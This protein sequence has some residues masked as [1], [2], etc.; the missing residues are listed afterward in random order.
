MNWKRSAICCVSFIA[1]F[2]GEIAV[3]IACGPEQDPYDYYVSYFHNNVQGDEYVPF[4]FNSM[5]ALFSEEEVASEAEINSAEWAAYLKVKK[6]D[7]LKAM[8][9]VDSAASAKLASFES[10]TID[11]LPDSLANNT[12]LDALTLAKN[13][14]AMD[15]YAY[16]KSCEPFASVNFDLWNPVVRD[17]IMMDK[18]AQEGL[19]LLRKAGGDDFLKLRYA[20]QAERLFHFAGNYQQSKSTYE[21]FI[22]P[23][24]TNS[25]AKGWALAVYAG[26]VRYTG[27]PAQAAFL[28]SKVF[29][30][31]PERR[32]QAYKNF[33]YTSAPVEEVLKYAKT[34]QE[35]ANVLA[36][37]SFGN[38]EPQ[39]EALQQVYRYVPS[40][41]LSGA[42][43][44]REVNK[45][46]EDLIK[47][48]DIAHNPYAAYLWRYDERNGKSDSTESLNKQR[49][50]KIRDF[51]L[52]L[53]ADKKYREPALGTVTAAY[54][55]WMEGNDGL[56]LSYL[57]K[58][59]AD[60]LNARLHDQY[61]IIELLIKGNQ[62]KRGSAFN[63]NDLLPALKW[64]DAKRFAENPDEAKNAYNNWFEGKDRFT[65]TTRNF[66]QQ[67]LAPAY[68]KMGDTAKAAMA[69]FKGDLKYR[70]TEASLDLS[71]M[72]YQTLTFFQN[73]LG[74]KTVQALAKI[75]Q[76][77][78]ADNVNGLL[79]HGF[80]KLNNDQ[81]YELC[82]TVY[83]RTHQ[84]AKALDWFKKVKNYS[85]FFEANNWYADE[86]MYSDPFPTTINDYPKRYAPL[87]KQVDKISFAKEMA[88]LQKLVVSDKKNAAS[89]YYKMANGVYQTGYYGNSWFLISYDWSSYFN[90][91]KP[92]YAHDIDFKLAKTAKAW[93]A[94]ARGLSNDVNFKAKCTFMLA[95]CEQK[96]IIINSNYYDLS[97]YNS[98]YKTQQQNFMAKN[99]N[100]PYFKELKASYAKTPYYKIAVNECSYLRDFLKGST[101]H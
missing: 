27:N 15:Y 74:P 11:E 1:V 4:A 23:I 50:V 71:S 40:S 91:N 101:V 93:Y 82:G 96:K 24:K 31:N 26:S 63:E 7:V 29:E 61:R 73:Y 99:I 5:V 2:F 100:N 78:Q 57:A 76:T 13:K 19:G 41:L 75:K 65:A 42:L 10:H 20:Y 56:A 70:K 79:A 30:S 54:L 39:V 51:A 21:K 3:N 59:N 35:K 89:Y 98:D 14:K 68:L 94:K 36:V 83:L 22:E 25:A 48:K 88:R 80:I 64:L 72:S 52:Q 46:E 67:V 69:M 77:P 85:A 55:S 44:V 33:F 43:L 92:V 28:Y 97:W 60:K 84:Y 53:A 58:V 37:K 47:D 87:G 18:K 62:I 32:I 95:K 45:L 12:F 49:L 17:S 86:K 90:Y 8:Y 6:E 9:Q 66:Y 16:A 81:F 38:P 34:N